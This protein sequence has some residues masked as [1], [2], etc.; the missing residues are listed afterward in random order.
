MHRCKQM[1]L[2]LSSCS[3]TAHTFVFNLADSALKDQASSGTWVDQSSQEALTQTPH[4]REPHLERDQPR[5][6]LDVSLQIPRLPL[7]W[8]IVILLG[9]SFLT[10]PMIGVFLC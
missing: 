10:L 9:F 7:L 4:L 6:R 5:F 1:S 3:G 2:R 8:E